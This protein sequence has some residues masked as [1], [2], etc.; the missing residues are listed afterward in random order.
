MAFL[1]FR[2][3]VRGS[4]KDG[5]WAPS[6]R[7]SHSINIHLMPIMNKAPGKKMW[8]NSKISCIPGPIGTWAP[9]E[10]MDTGKVGYEDE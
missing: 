6:H 8:G 5:F 10:E 3:N 2:T 7:L 4:I 1:A 9:K